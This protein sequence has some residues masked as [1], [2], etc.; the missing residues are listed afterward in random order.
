MLYLEALL[1]PMPQ[2]TRATERF[3]S[4][5]ALNRLPRLLEMEKSVYINRSSVLFDNKCLLAGKR[6]IFQTPLF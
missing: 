4:L 3:A 1:W 6:K 5:P 2:P